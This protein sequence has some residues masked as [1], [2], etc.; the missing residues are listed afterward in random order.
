MDSFLDNSDGE[1]PGLAVASSGSQSASR[2]YGDPSWQSRLP[3]DEV[4]IRHVKVQVRHTKY[5]IFV[6]EF[7]LF[8]EMGK[9]ARCM[10]LAG[11]GIA[12]FL[13]VDLCLDWSARSPVELEWQSLLEDFD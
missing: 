10:M 8:L 4:H 2:D 12:P 9:D 6:E 7:R 1:K 11:V 13:C 5:P 3:E